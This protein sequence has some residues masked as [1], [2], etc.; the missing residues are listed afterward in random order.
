MKEQNF[1]NHSRLV[2]L[3]H[4]LTA[5]LIVLGVVGAI[6]NLVRAFGNGGGRLTAGLVVLLFVIGALYFWFIRSFALGA[7]DRAIRAEE[8]LRYFSITGKLLDS[9]LT[10]GQIIALRFAP[11]GEFVSLA[12]RAVK[13]NLKSA[14]IKQ[15]IQNWRADNH[16]I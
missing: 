9:R 10:L 5:L 8:N 12:D 14:E 2:P 1:K 15:A 16:R 3:F 6:V 4:G 7:Q 13:E 11:D